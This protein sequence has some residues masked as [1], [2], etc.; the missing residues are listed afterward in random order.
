MRFRKPRDSGLLKCVGLLCDTNRSSALGSSS[1]S[2]N[3]IGLQPVETGS[4]GGGMIASRTRLLCDTNHSSAL[5]SS[6]HSSNS[7]GLQ[8]VETGCRGGGG[9][10]DSVQD[11]AAL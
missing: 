4:R 11:K 5:G 3:S 1:H 7:I 2:S 9:G 6:S 10:D 8:P